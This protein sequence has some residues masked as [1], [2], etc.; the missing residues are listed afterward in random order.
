MTSHIPAS[1]YGHVGATYFDK[2]YSPL[3][4]TPCLRHFIFISFYFSVFL[5]FHID[6]RYSISQSLSH[7]TTFT[8]NMSW[9]LSALTRSCLFEQPFSSIKITRSPTTIFHSAE[10]PGD[11]STFRPHI[12]RAPLPATPHISSPHDYHGGRILSTRRG[13][14][15]FHAF[16]VP[17]PTRKF[18]CDG[19]RLSKRYFSSASCYFAHTSQPPRDTLTICFAGQ[20]LSW[21]PHSSFFRL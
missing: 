5:T 3:H 12:S 6:F 1:F 7:T 17:A 18:R 8:F 19:K 2:I 10:R 13:A 16:A 15:L 11:Y 9:L 4:T 21:L 14:E 20:Y